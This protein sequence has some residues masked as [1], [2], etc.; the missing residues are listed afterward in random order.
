MARLRVV[1]LNLWGTTEPLGRRME[2]VEAGLRALE[3][4]LVGLQEV[5]E[6]PGK[7]P[8]QAETLARALGMLHAFAPAMEV[9]PE[10]GGG[11]EGDA[12]LSRY[13]I[14]DEERVDLP[15]ATTDE[16]RV[17]LRCAIETPSGMMHAMVTHLNWRMRHGREREDQVVV[18]DEVASRVQ[19]GMPRVLM[20]DFNATPDCDEIRFLAGKHTIGGRRT[21]WQD[22]FARCNPGAPGWTWARRNSGTERLAFL[23]PDR[24]LDYVFV[25]PPARDG[26]GTIVESRVVLDLPSADGTWPSDHFGLFAVIDL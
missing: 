23:E 17:L 3:P 20:G 25:T 15:H 2:L 22:A 6:V 14:K 21:Y 13:P 26:R 10:H 5:R 11:V 9:L 8:N 1:T 18:I 7:V 4:D 24:R 12:I 19:S 16:R